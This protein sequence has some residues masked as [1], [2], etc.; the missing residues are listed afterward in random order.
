MNPALFILFFFW[1]GGGD[2]FCEEGRVV[3]HSCTAAEAWLHAGLQP[4]Q[5]LIVSACE[6][7]AGQ[8]TQI[9]AAQPEEMALPEI[10]ARA[11]AKGG[12]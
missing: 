9:A 4:G 8:N 7:A 12:E 1:C 11:N 2:V 10:A 3:H 5:S 6:T